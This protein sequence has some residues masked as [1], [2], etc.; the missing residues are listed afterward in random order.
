M[1]TI[2]INALRKLCKKNSMTK[3]TKITAKIKSWITASADS[4]VKIELSL[5]ILISRLLA[6][7]S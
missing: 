6:L 4:K 3:A 5:T 2:T 7:Y 1:D